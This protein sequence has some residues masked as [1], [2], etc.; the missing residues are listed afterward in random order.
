M[1]ILSKGQTKTSVQSTPAQFTQRTAAAAN[2][3]FSLLAIHL[4]AQLT[5]GLCFYLY[6]H[7]STP[8][9]MSILLLFVP[10]SAIYFLSLHLGKT[11]NLLSTPLGKCAGTLF[12]FCLLIDALMSLAAFTALVRE[13]LPDYNSALIVLASLICV[14]PAFR[15][16]NPHALPS[17]AHLLRFPL[18][19]AFAFSMLGTLNQGN[20]GNLFPLLGME[21]KRILTGGLWMCGCLSPVL[22]PLFLP[23]PLQETQKRKGFASL[24]VALLL[25]AGT[26]LLAAYLLPFYFLSRPETVGT[27]L[28]LFLKVNTSLLAWSLMVC[29]MML[30]LLI[31]LSCAL[32]QCFR[33][34]GCITRKNLSPWAGLLL[35]PLPALATDGAMEWLVALASVRGWLL[36]GVLLAALIGT[37]GRK[38][39]K[40][41]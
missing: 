17:L 33:L 3:R 40:S 30:L 11:E 5:A 1:S 21:G 28:L 34:F 26:A 10:L 12:V 25:G 7:V 8:S 24:S 4:Y 41:A 31:S 2:N 38:D 15:A 22:S 36:A 35:L 13:M 37:I 23:D 39:R 9:Y 20:G 18:L 19:L 29:G 6:R 16:R 32:S 14:M 27:Q